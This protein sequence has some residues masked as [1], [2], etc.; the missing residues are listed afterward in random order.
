MTLDIAQMYSA[1]KERIGLQKKDRNK[2]IGIGLTMLI[3]ITSK[4]N[5]ILHCVLGWSVF[6]YIQGWV[7]ALTL[8]LEA[9]AQALSNVLEAPGKKML[10]H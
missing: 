3:T 4:I 10:K 5:P 2:G 1:E 7:H 6:C 9:Q 8:V